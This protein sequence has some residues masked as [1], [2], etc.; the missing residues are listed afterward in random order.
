[1]KSKQLKEDGI[2][3][4]MGTS[5]STPGTGAIDTIDPFL[6]KTKKKL[7]SVITRKPL[8][9]IRASLS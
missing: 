8:E 4:V 3:N 5:S 7:S 6:K 2:A 9:D 1:M